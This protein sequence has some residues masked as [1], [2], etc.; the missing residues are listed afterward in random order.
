M[1]KFYA[2]RLWTIVLIF[3]VA[4][5]IEEVCRT[6]IILSDMHDTYGSEFRTLRERD[7]LIKG[8]ARR[9]LTL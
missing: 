2:R 6:G 9:K 3:E 4:S 8:P 1:F 5:Q 7:D